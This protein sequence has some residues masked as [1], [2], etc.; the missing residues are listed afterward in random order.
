MRLNG[1]PANVLARRHWWSDDLPRWMN[2]LAH[3]T[4]LW[5]LGSA[6]SVPLLMWLRQRTLDQALE[7]VVIGAITGAVTYGIGLL[8]YELGRWWSREPSSSNG[9]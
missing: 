8:V 3:Y 9:A 1:Q 4:C 2:R 7:W 5:L 6:L